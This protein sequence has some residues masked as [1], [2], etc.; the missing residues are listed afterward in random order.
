MESGGGSIETSDIIAGVPTG[1]QMCHLWNTRRE[2]TTLAIL[3]NYFCD[4]GTGLQNSTDFG[5][6]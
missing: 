6:I 1:T 5:V 3:L 4:F 2:H